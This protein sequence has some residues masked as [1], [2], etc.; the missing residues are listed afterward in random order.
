MP[1]IQA[2][3]R[4]WQTNSSLLLA[5]SAAGI[6]KQR[7]EVRQS[8]GR[9]LVD[10]HLLEP[11]RTPF[12][13]MLDIQHLTDCGTGCLAETARDAC[14]PP[15]ARPCTRRDARLS[16]TGRRV[17]D[18]KCGNYRGICGLSEGGGG[19]RR[20]MWRRE[21]DSNPRRAY[22]PY[23]LSRGAPSTTRPSLRCRKSLSFSFACRAH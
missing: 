23:T 13:Q 21:R 10:G 6:F 5:P 4:G 15:C 9:R 17:A 20:A 8:R 11:H 3:F 22:D 12:E 14:N 1:T 7:L 2:N 19:L 18:R 16:R